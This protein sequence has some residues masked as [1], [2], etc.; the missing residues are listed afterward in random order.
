ML[1]A[2]AAMPAAA[3]HPYLVDKI[4]SFHAVFFMLRR[5]SNDESA[6]AVNFFKTTYGE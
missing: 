6:G 4:F 2:R 5:Q 1:D 3:K